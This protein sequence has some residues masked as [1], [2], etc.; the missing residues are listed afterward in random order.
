MEEPL[1]FALLDETALALSEAGLS[2]EEFRRLTQHAT[3]SAE[4]DLLALARAAA[5]GA[6]RRVLT[7]YAI[8]GA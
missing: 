6:E 2:L 5:R 8:L 4:L 7:R 3:T 1:L